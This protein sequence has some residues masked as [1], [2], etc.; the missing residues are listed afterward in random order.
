MRKLLTIAFGS[1]LVVALAVVCHAATTSIVWNIGPYLPASPPPAGGFPTAGDGFWNAWPPP[2]GGL[3]YGAGQEAYIGVEDPFGPLI[4]WTKNV[5]VYIWGGRPED[6]EGIGWNQ[7]TGISGGDMHGNSAPETWAVQ[8]PGKGS[9]AT[10]EVSMQF[11]GFQPAGEWIDLSRASGVSKITQVD[12]RTVCTC[13]KNK[14]KLQDATSTLDPDDTD[15]EPVD[16]TQLWYFPD[17]PIDTTAV[18]TLDAPAGTGPWTYQYVSTDPYGN[19]M[20]DGGIEWT[21]TGVGVADDATIECDLT[22]LSTD[23]V[24]VTEDFYDADSG[25]Y[26]NGSGACPEPGAFA[27]LGIGAIGLLRRPRKSV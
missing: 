26:M 22:N 24:V 5:Q 21:T 13:V 2:G 15:P 3:Q 17:V 10:F 1:C 4:G 18:P 16:L 12:W 20:P 25:L 27:L 14:A 6:V 8:N 9:T 23:G 11:T 7:S 19:E